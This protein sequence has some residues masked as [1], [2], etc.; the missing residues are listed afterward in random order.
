MNRWIVSIAIAASAGTANVY[1]QLPHAADVP[2]GQSENADVDFLRHANTS[3]V[4]QMMLGRT[5]AKKT[6]TSGV[7]E[8][9]EAVAKSHV[10]A[11]DALKILAA[12]KHVD[13]PGGPGADGQA[14]VDDLNGNHNADADRQYVSQVIRD[15]DELIAFYQDA[16]DHSQD[17]DIRAHAATMLPALREHRERAEN[18]LSS[19]LGR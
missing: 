1:A 17:A 2:A 14:E 18:L 11:N 10:K 12:A 9:G 5:A 15:N 8:L 16:A 19:A 4:T 3:N 7:R 6:K 13:L